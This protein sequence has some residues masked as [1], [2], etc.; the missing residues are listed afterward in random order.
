[1]NEGHPLRPLVGRGD[2]WEPL[3]ARFSCDRCGAE[4][5]TLTLLPPFAPDP[6]APPTDTL[7]GDIPFQ[8]AVRLSIDGPVKT[9]HTF[10]PGIEVDLPTLDAALRAHDVEQIYGLDREYAPFWCRACRKSYCR[11]CWVVWVDY[12]E[13]FYDC[14]R[15]RCPDGHE[16]IMDD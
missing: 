8:D 12:D 2:A 7:R 11:D 6:Q 13:G 10:L 4:A 16:R 5:C 1:M 14:T 15:G 3:V 9:T